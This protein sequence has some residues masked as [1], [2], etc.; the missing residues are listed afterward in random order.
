MT[1]VLGLE[2][3]RARSLVLWLGLLA[4]GYAGAIAA[5][6][7]TVLEAATS[8]DELLELYP[9]G[10]LAALGLEGS[11]TDAGVFLNSYVFQFLWPLLAAIA[12]LLLATRV[13]VDAE[14]GFLDLPLSTPV[15]RTGYLAASIVG[16]AIA[17][18]GLGAVTVLAIEAVDL[19]I[20]PDFP[21]LGLVLAGCQAILFAFA[22]AGATT[23][24]AVLTLSRG[25]AAG[26]AAAV[27]LLMYLLNV[28]ASLSPDLAGLGRV[29]AFH[30][31][32][33]ADV[34]RAERF[35][36]GDG[37]LFAIVAGGGWAAAL[38]AFR[39]RDLAA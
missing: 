6:Y 33:L 37:L 31:F 18:A 23:L 2:L 16:Q 26:L 38:I 39:Q 29:S 4:A 25:K 28:V 1:T 36:V 3:R 27:L 11:L 10:L 8:F 12:A 32:A 9:E 7:P 22:I 14:R 13:A 19:V 15:S 24:L 5:F 21:V 20:E 34:I 17:I 35:P 30:Y